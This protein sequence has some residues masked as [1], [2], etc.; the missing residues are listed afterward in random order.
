MTR[1]QKALDDL[2]GWSGTSEIDLYP[3]VREVFTDVF[4]YPKDHIARAW[5]F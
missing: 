4:G 5:V 3:Y 1:S 2:L